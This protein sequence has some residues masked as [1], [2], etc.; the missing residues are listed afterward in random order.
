MIGLLR[1]ACPACGRQAWKRAGKTGASEVNPRRLRKRLLSVAILLAFSQDCPLAQQKQHT[2]SP[3]E[4]IRRAIER[5]KWAQKQDH[6]GQFAFR[7]LVVVENLDDKG[8][9]KQREES[10]FQATP[11]EGTPF[12][13]PIQKDGKPLSDKERKEAE[14]RQRKFRERLAENRRKKEKQ[15]SKDDDDLTVSE[16]LVSRFRFELL[17]R[18]PV[19]GRP[20][21][22]L[23]FEPRSEDLPTRRKL[24]RILNKLAGKV[25]LDQESYEISKLEARL[26]EKTK[27]GWGI[28]G[29]VE[30]LEFTFEQRQVAENIWLPSRLDLYIRAR[31]LFS[32]LHQWEKVEWSEFKRVVE[33][34]GEQ[35]IRKR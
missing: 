23:A 17:G 30:R 16:E 2:P 33:R 7:Q 32:S 22:V 12:Y 31:M 20:A 26:T 9:V 29:S 13:Q 21:Y 11:I 24:D 14:E 4:I 8:A 10:L 3:E 35:G 6:A 1:L 28:I 18:Q 15:K 34:E 25:W 19:D 5:A 27:F